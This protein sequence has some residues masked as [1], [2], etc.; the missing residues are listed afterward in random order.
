MSQPDLGA[1]VKAA[2]E[3]GAGEEL[4]GQ[5]GGRFLALATLD[6]GARCGL[7]EAGAWILVNDG[8]AE[9]VR[10]SAEGAYLF[11]EALEWKRARFE[12]AL[13][14]GARA[15]GLPEGDVVFS[16]PAVAV[17]R[18]V[19]AR[20]AAYMTRL[21]L[22]WVLP[23]ELRELRADIVAVRKHDNMP[24]PVKQL[25]ERLIVPE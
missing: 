9:P 13:E 4:P 17:V 5:A 19:L 3:H 18:A 20:Q 2:L 21:A 14:E 16:F 15:L 12:S 24:A 6:S 1:H 25:A 10:F 8:A 11:H 7:D 22:E 23:S